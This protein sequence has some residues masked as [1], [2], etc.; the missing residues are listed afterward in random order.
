MIPLSPPPPPTPPHPSPPHLS[1]LPLLLMFFLLITSMTRPTQPSCSAT[2]PPSSSSSS[3][4]LMHTM[5]DT[6]SHAHCNLSIHIRIASWLADACRPH[7][8]QRASENPQYHTSRR[9]H[10]QCRLTARKIR[11]SHTARRELLN[12]PHF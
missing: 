5:M 7:T 9:H 2:S 10:E 1:S 11:C 8:R 4:H 3:Y 12:M 6:H